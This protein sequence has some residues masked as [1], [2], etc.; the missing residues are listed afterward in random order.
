PAVFSLHIGSVILPG[1]MIRNKDDNF[2]FR[3]EKPIEFHP[4]GK[5]GEDTKALVST[6]IKVIESYV[7]KYPDQWYM[8]RRFWLQ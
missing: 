4:T 5:T 8:F 2:T 1:F 6:Y 7:R 3:F